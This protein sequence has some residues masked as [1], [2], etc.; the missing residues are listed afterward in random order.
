M[1][2]SHELAKYKNI[3]IKD[4]E[5]LSRS[6]ERV[7]MAVLD[8]KIEEAQLLKKWVQGAIKCA[9]SKNRKCDV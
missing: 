9:R 3:M 6:H 7:W 4:F 8:Q 5:G 1:K 2:I